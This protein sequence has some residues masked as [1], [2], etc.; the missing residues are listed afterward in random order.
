MAEPGCPAA[1]IEPSGNHLESNAFCADFV[2]LSGCT[3]FGANP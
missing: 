2:S 3:I 1:W